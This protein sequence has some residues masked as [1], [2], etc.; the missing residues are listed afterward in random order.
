MDVIIN[1][2]NV[3]TEVIVDKNKLEYFVSFRLSP[4][5]RR[6]GIIKANGNKN[7]YVKSAIDGFVDRPADFFKAFWNISIKYIKNEVVTWW[8]LC[9]QNSNVN[10]NFIFTIKYS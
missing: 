6:P 4:G 7:K 8:E 2:I 3:N 1:R 9:R 10:V 5:E